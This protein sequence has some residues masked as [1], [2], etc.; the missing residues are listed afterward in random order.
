MMARHEQD[1]RG[2]HIADTSD[3][4]ATQF[5][6]SVSTRFVYGLFVVARSIGA[7]LQHVPPPHHIRKAAAQTKPSRT[8]PRGPTPPRRGTDGI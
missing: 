5:D 8:K 1:G 4:P 7:R 2:A 6:D 3:S